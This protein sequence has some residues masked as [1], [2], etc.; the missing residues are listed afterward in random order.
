M[1]NTVKISRILQTVILLNAAPLL[2]NK[3]DLVVFLHVFPESSIIWCKPMKILAD[4]GYR[5]IAPDQRGYSE[6]ARPLGVENYTT[7]EL[8][9]DV[10][11]LADA[12]GNRGK[13]HLV[14]M[15]GGQ[16]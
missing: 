1:S 3:G 2:E 11:A 4:R 16:A 15:T 12:V 14:G 7:R 13:F 10:L 8:S 9:K 6:G 5:C